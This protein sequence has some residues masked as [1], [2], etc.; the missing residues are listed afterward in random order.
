VKKFAAIY[1]DCDEEKE[2]GFYEDQNMSSALLEVTYGCQLVQFGK[3]EARLIGK[4]L[5]EWGESE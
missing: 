1:L 2:L 3:L 4:I 5:T